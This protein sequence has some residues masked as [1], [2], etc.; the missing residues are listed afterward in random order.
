MLARAPGLR[1]GAAGRRHRPADGRRA[2]AHATR[3]AARSHS[4]RGA[5]A[6]TCRSSSIGA[7]RAHGD[8]LEPALTPISDELE[9]MRLALELGLRDYVEKNGFREVV[10][11]VSGG[12]DSA[13]DRRA[14]RRGARAGARAL[15]LDAVALLLGGDARRRAAARGESRLRLPRAPDRAGRRGVR[16]ARCAGLRGPRARPRRGEPPGA[17]PRRRC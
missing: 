8:A 15:R 5:A 13:L 16:P 12:I 3:A 14:R 9:Q 4:E 6:A 1:G 2:A 11:G 17:D 7:A 10:V